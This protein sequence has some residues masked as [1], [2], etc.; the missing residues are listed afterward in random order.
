MRVYPRIKQALAFDWPNAPAGLE[1]SKSG[2]HVFKSVQRP[3]ITIKPHPYLRPALEESR[4]DTVKIIVRSVI[5]AI[6][7]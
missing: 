5:G 7:S 6:K 2:K 3:Q 1:P 4:A